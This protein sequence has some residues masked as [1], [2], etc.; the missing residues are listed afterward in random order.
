MNVPYI[1]IHFYFNLLT[2]I[3]MTNKKNIL[4]RFLSLTFVGDCT[5]K[6]QR[7]FAEI[8]LCLVKQN[9]FIEFQRSLETFVCKLIETFIMKRSDGLNIFEFQ[10]LFCFELAF[11][12]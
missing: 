10:V 3:D 2:T 9:Y 7:L 6:L 5:T 11:A 1:E 12:E 8:K 4:K